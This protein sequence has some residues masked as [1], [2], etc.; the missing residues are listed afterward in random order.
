MDT[1]RWLTSIEEW[2]L[3]ILMVV[4]FAFAFIINWIA[5]RYVGDMIARNA[6]FLRVDTTNYNFLRNAFSFIIYTGAALFILSRIPEF[7][8]A[9]KTIFTATGIVAAIIALASQQAL[10]NIFSGLFIIVFKPFRVEDIIEMEP[11][12]RGIV[13]DITLRHTIIR[14][15]ENKR[16]IVPNSVINNTV[17]INSDIKDQPIRR[18]MHLLVSYDAPI[19][20]VF[21]IIEDEVKKHPYHLERRSEL[22]ILEGIPEVE[23]RILEYRETG[24][25]V[26][27]FLWAE[28]HIKAFRLHTDVNYAIKKRFDAAGILFPYPVRRVQVESFPVNDSAMG[29]GLPKKAEED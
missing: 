22:D 5:R 24:L 15:F 16:I 12:R 18:H 19:D 7:K 13:E 25:Y 6:D 3:P 23:I 14:D 21:A 26:R 10:A 29:A 27:V 28:D 20:R 9:S 2:Y 17:I 1:F 11:G 4:V 8:S